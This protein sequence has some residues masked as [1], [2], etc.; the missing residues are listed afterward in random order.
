MIHQPY[1]ALFITNRSKLKAYLNKDT[2][3]ILFSAQPMPRNGDQHF[4][5]RENSD[6]F[7][8]T[9]IEQEYSALILTPTE[10]IL[11]IQEQNE[12]H[13]LWEGDRLTPEQASS[14]SG[15]KQV[16]PYSQLESYLHK[17]AQNRHHLYFN[18]RE[19][20]VSKSIQSPDEFF[21]SNFREKYP[22]YQYHSARGI[23]EKLRIKKEPGEIE[24]IRQ[25]IHITHSAF[26]RILQKT[27]PGINENELEAELRHEFQLKHSVPAYD[28]ILASG[29][30]ACVL[31]YT[32]NNRNCQNGDLLLMDIGAE[33]HNYAADIS[34]T[35][36][37]NGKYSERQRVCYEAVLEVQKR[38]IKAAIP[39]KSL[40]D[41]NEQ[42]KEWLSEKHIELGLYTEKDKSEELIHTY[43]PHGV[44]HFMGLDVHDC[45]NKETILEEGM[46]IT[47]EPGLY[48]PGE[49][50]GI[51]I[52]DDILV[53]KQP[54]NL[55]RE[56]PKEIAEIEKLMNSTNDT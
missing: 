40:S 46:V 4:P 37:V 12:K 15:I 21:F 20:L 30:N 39:G 35:V 38:A 23:I 50:I 25:S 31:H 33:K 13:K 10:D 2:L 9:G 47:C 27:K 44:S 29:K 22:F 11:F 5:Y 34:R 8:F 16:E 32:K 24:Y 55:S 49:N 45:G 6:F 28:P 51:R 19:P 54:V 3:A 56:I 48:I 26:E 42:V 36:P 18:I 7:Y 52:E 43:F 41:L 14:L 17:L 1:N 53:G